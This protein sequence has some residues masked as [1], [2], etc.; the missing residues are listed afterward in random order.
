[1]NKEVI[2]VV[3]DGHVTMNKPN[4]GGVDAAENESQPVPAIA[5]D[6]QKVIHSRF[7]VAKSH[8]KKLLTQKV[9]KFC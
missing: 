5:D 2:V 9:H 1:M 6:Q 8:I 4:G 7:D 3:L